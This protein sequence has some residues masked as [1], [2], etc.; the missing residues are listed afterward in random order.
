MAPNM[1]GMRA[2]DQPRM[3]NLAEMVLAFSARALKPGGVLLL[4][5][6]QGTGFEQFIRDLRPHFDKVSI[7]KPKASRDRSSETYVLARGLVY[8]E[9]EVVDSEVRH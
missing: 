9:P 5:S 6:F 3:M 8:S 4:K 1:S 2:V 7:R